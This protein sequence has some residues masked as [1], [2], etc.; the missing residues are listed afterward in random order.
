[1]RELVARVKNQFRAQETPVQ[2]VRCVDIEL[3]RASCRAILNGKEV[4]LTATEFRLLEFLMSH[5]GVIYSR[6]QLPSAVWGDDRAVTHGTVDVYIRRVRKKIEAEP[7]RPAF[8]RAVHRFGYSFNET[9]VESVSAQHCETQGSRFPPSFAPDLAS[10][11]RV[12]TSTRIGG[13][14][15]F[16][17][18]PETSSHGLG[19]R[20]LHQIHTSESEDPELLTANLFQLCFNNVVL[21]AR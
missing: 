1:M 9:I 4:A 3:D 13:G 19:T 16:V 2:V 14:K 11:P 7:T 6:E 8:L 21:L 10:V 20:R 15:G 18:S 17:Y 12:F 5:P